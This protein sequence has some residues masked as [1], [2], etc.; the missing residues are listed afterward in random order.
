VNPGATRRP[1]ARCHDDRPRGCPDLLPEFPGAA[2]KGRGFD[3]ERAP[4]PRTGGFRRNFQTFLLVFPGERP[5][6][7]ARRDDLRTPTARNG[8]S[9]PDVPGLAVQL[10]AN[11]GRTRVPAGAADF[12]AM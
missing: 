1:G 5:P 6:G 10:R 12:V 3:L 7:G 2:G 11:D 9:R 4:T 8:L